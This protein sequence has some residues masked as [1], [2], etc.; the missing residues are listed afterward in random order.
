MSFEHDQM[1]HE[2]GK[3]VLD[4]LRQGNAAWATPRLTNRVTYWQGVSD[5]PRPDKAFE[6]S[7]T[8]ASFAI[9]FKPPGQPKREYVT[10]I[11]QALTYL[12]SFEFAALVLPTRADDGYPIAEYVKGVLEQECVDPAP[13]ALFSYDATPSVLT[14]A[15]PLRARTTAFVAPSRGNRDVFWAYWRELSPYEV[16]DLLIEMDRRNATLNE[17]YQ[18]F[19]KTK[20]TKGLARLWEGACR[21][22]K[23]RD[24]AFGSERANASLSMRHIGL[25]ESSGRMTEEGYELLRHGKIYGADSESFRMRLGNQILGV[26]KHLDLIFWMDEQQRTMSGGEKASAQTYYRA[27]DLALQAAGVIRQAPQ[28]RAKPTFLRDEQK[29]WNKLRLLV[30]Y[31]GGQYFHPGVG[32]VFNWR[33]IVAMTNTVQ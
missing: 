3:F 19:W 22:K 28:G 5:W 6:D 12:R 23:A 8:G 14:S 10:G 13:L 24:A 17:A 11:G 21:K 25:V 27:M 26:G 4:S 33:T 32:L 20:L 29:L 31:A 9:E 2:S 15:R 16:L 1:A 30:P 18:R 7:S